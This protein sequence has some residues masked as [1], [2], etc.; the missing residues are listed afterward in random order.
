MLSSFLSV[1]VVSASAHADRRHLPYEEP[2]RMASSSA[3]MVSFWLTPQY[4]HATG[5]I[6]DGTGTLEPGE[7]NR[8]DLQNDLG[9]S[10]HGALVL[11]IQLEHKNRY[12]P[13]VRFDYLP[14][15]FFGTHGLS[16]NLRVG[17]M[18]FQAGQQVQTRFQ[19]IA[20]DLTLLYHPLRL[21]AQARPWLIAALGLTV[22]T[23]QAALDVRGVGIWRVGSERYDVPLVP[24]AYVGFDVTPFRLLGFSAEARGISDGDSQ[25]WDVSAEI[26]SWPAG[27]RTFV[28][29]GARYQLLDVAQPHQGGLDAEVI[30]G[31]ATVGVR[32]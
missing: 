13:D 9:L 10:A 25:W 16:K 1:A 30:A 12:W 19:A 5:V 14:L 11:G 15:E 20:L 31:Q 26:R 22:R 23:T 24:M 27:P 29:V 4:Q 21:G 8:T 3:Y 7:V 18:S 28:G 6:I 2:E 32:F 17:Q